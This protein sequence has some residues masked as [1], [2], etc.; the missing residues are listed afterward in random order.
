MITEESKTVIF[1][2]EETLIHISKDISTADII[3]PIKK[4]GLKQTETAQVI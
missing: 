4:I 1:D 2:L 3:L